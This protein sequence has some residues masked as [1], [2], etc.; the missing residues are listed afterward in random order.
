M[1]DFISI[2]SDSP[3]VNETDLSTD[4]KYLLEI[5]RTVISGNC[6]ESLA[7]RDPGKVSHSRWL[8]L[9]NRLLRLYVGTPTASENLRILVTYIVKVYAPVWFIIKCHSHCKN[10]AKNLF[11][12]VRRSRYLSEDLRA[13]IDPVI[14]RNAYFGHPENIILAMLCDDRQ[15]IRELALRRILN[16]RSKEKGKTIRN[17]QIPALNLEAQD[18]IA[19]INWQD[20]KIT[21]PPLTM[22]YSE[23]ELKE[24]IALG[25]VTEDGTIMQFP[26]FP[27][28]T[29]AVERCVKLVTEASSAVCGPEMVS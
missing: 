3:E 21:E 19:L 27:C 24:I 17:F 18:Y 26:N 1:V 11:E 9:A 6:G 10:G 5:C 25:C 2:E 13:V 12:L 14:Q 23:H 4:Q 8:T 7:Q 28:H 22:R 29:Q 20:Y 16:A 15:H